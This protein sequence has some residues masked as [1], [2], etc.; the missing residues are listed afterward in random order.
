MAESVRY[1]FTG[2]TPGGLLLGLGPARVAVMGVSLAGAAALLYSRVTP[3][4]SVGLVAVATAWCF[5]PLGGRPVHQWSGPALR[6]GWAVAAG[7]RHWRAG[8]RDLRALEDAPGRVGVALPSELGRLQ[9]WRDDTAGVEQVLAVERAAGGVGVTAV[10][11]VGGVDRFALLDPTEQARLVS[12][13]GDVLASM[14][15]A[16]ELR[17]L[18]WVE[19]GEPE[20]TVPGIDWMAER[21]ADAPPGDR[22]HYLALGQQIASAGVTHTV[23]LGAQVEVRTGDVEEAINRAA[24]AWRLLASRLAGSGLI[25][26]PLGVASLGSLIRSHYDMDAPRY[27]ARAG[28]TPALSLR[29]QSRRTAWDHLRADD[30]FHRSYLVSAWPR[31]PVGPAWL[32]PLLLCAPPGAARS[33]AVHLEAVDAPVAMRRARA[34]RLAAAMD[35]TQRSRLG[36]VSGAGHLRAREEAD[37]R[38]EELVSG[39]AEHRAGAVVTVSA[40]SL[41]EL[42]ASCREVRAAATAA[43]MELR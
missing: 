21:W 31:V 25:A 8:I 5:L 15:P 13:W 7:A 12:L 6:H 39:F 36:F 32:E 19:R 20:G 23:H 34:A 9:L 30:T 2:G 16:Q 37:A 3:V 11:A 28:R 27:A 33:L 18:C 35:D 42:D 41:S 1:S 10:F 24:P 22:D 17:R 29:L 26:T 14:G 4:A 43:R 40:G 38:E